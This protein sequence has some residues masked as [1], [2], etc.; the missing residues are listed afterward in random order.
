MNR[1][2]SNGIIIFNEKYSNYDKLSEITEAGELYDGDGNPIVNYQSFSYSSNPTY[3]CDPGSAMDISFVNTNSDQE[4][5][6]SS[7]L[8]IPPG[9]LKMYNPLFLLDAIKLFRSDTLQKN[10][11]YLQENSF[12]P[13][14]KIFDSLNAIAKYYSN[15][16]HGRE[17]NQKES[18]QFAKG[19]K[20]SND[21]YDTLWWKTIE[22]YWDM[23]MNN[24]DVAAGRR[25]TIINDWLERLVLPKDYGKEENDLRFE[26]AQNWI[27]DDFKKNQKVADR[28][29]KDDMSQLPRPIRK[30]FNNPKTSYIYFQNGVFGVGQHANLSKSERQILIEVFR[31]PENLMI[32]F[33][34]LLLTDMPIF[35]LVPS[36]Y[37][38]DL[39]W[40]S[41]ADFSEDEL[42]QPITFFLPKA[43][44][45][46]LNPVDAD[47][48]KGSLYDYGI[49]GLKEQTGLTVAPNGIFS[50]VGIHNPILGGNINDF[51]SFY[52]DKNPAMIGNFEEINRIYGSN[53]ILNSTE[54][55]FRFYFGGKFASENDQL[56]KSH[57]EVVEEYLELRT[58]R[59]S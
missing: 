13:D 31:N 7:I 22:V 14:E 47:K 30:L 32:Y 53:S 1:N 6:L 4:I 25:D 55:S 45:P 57:L 39:F 27:R 49:F 23:L 41:R 38:D 12:N 46:F 50:K 51:M 11:N 21:E 28:K 54:N 42:K 33:R 43:R 10:L 9:S 52:H 58:S 2:T 36:L 15:M 35:N 48:L 20:E 56:I 5:F 37:F 17:Y 18:E 8:N 24:E 29:P 3:T 19:T 34:N 44:I 40:N 59:V 16:K 26:A